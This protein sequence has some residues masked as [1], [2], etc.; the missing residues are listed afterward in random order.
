VL[1]CSEVGSTYL[2]ND[3]L[4]LAVR[5]EIRC[6]LG[7][8]RHGPTARAQ[9]AAGGWGGG[10]KRQV[11]QL[12]QFH[13][14]GVQDGLRMHAKQSLCANSF[15]TPL[16]PVCHYQP[17]FRRTMFTRT[18]IMNFKKVTVVY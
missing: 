11:L 5:G 4:V 14:R 15:R 13:V 18:E 6:L 8:Y 9:S 17:N 10:C 3:G 7:T 16:L 1:R 12:P 2:T